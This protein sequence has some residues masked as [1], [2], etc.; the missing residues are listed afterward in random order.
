MPQAPRAALPHAA[1]WGLA[2]VREPLRAGQARDAEQVPPHAVPA[3]DAAP[4]VWAFAALLVLPL[5]RHCYPPISPAKGVISGQGGAPYQ[6]RHC[7]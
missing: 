5:S 2:S 3:L 1:Q 7:G 4:R 6:S